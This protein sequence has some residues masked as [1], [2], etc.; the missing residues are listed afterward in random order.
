MVSPTL[1]SAPHA[2]VIS[3]AAGSC[4]DGV[5]NGGTGMFAAAKILFLGPR[6]EL[7]GGFALGLRL[8]VSGVSCGCSLSIARRSIDKPFPSEERNASATPPEA[9]V[10]PR[11]HGPFPFSNTPVSSAAVA[12]IADTAAGAVGSVDAVGAIAFAVAVIAAA[13]DFERGFPGGRREVDGGFFFA[14]GGT[15]SVFFGFSELDCLR[16]IFDRGCWYVG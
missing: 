6:R 13:A 11:L 8:E 16:F 14:F 9:D 7:D 15:V 5:G 2:A 4:G 10:F 12:A 1:R 3:A